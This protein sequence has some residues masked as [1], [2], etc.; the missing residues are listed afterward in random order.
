ME[1]AGALHGAPIIIST[2]Q[3]TI[4]IRGTIPIFSDNPW[5]QKYVC[6]TQQELVISRKHPNLT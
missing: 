2:A 3:N 6:A 1:A 4:P 5:T